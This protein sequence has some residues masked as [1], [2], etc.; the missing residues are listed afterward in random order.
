MLAEKII[1]CFALFV[2]FINVSE[3]AGSCVDP[4]WSREADAPVLASLTD[5]WHCASLESL[6]KRAPLYSLMDKA[7]YVYVIGE[8]QCS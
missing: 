7:A 4:T 1:A 5:A 2:V 3:D 8:I 6:S